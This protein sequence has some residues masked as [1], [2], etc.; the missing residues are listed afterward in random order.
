MR[1]PWDVVR[2]AS[3]ISTG[4]EGRRHRDEVLVVKQTNRESAIPGQN[5]ISTRRFRER[6]LSTL[7]IVGKV[8]EVG[9]EVSLGAR[10]DF[11]DE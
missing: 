7:M 11:H 9:H 3:I 1:E 4:R 10:N 5:R 8:P 6:Q 2:T